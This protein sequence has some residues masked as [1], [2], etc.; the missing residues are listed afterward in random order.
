MLDEL[1]AFWGCA[2]DYV[3]DEDCRNLLKCGKYVERLDLCIRLDYH[4]KDLEKEYRKLTN[5]LGR[6][7]L[8]YNEKN[9]TRLGQLIDRGMGQEKDS[10]EALECLMGL[11]L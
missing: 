7:N 2:D 10:Q 4:K 1:L 3:E 11:F 8:R 6:I 5:R 9:L